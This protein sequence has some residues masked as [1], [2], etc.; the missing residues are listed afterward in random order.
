ML[1]PRSLWVSLC[2][3]TAACV[4]G[5]GG[6]DRQA[7]EDVLAEARVGRAVA[8]RLAKRY[9]IIQDDTLVRYLT[10]VGRTNARFS[11]RAELPFHFG[12]LRTPEVNAYACPGGYIFVTAGALLLMEDEAELAA[13]LAHEISHVSLRHAG[14]FDSSGSW[15]D[16]VTALLAGPGGNVLNSAVKTA[17]SEIEKILLEKGRQRDLE[18]D[19][20]RAGL[21]LSRSAG[22][23]AGAAERYL[24][25]LASAANSATLK[26][27]H[28]S[29]DVRLRFVAEFR[30]DQIEPGGA[31]N[32]ERFQEF[33]RRL[34]SIPLKEKAP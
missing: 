25:R 34:T 1:A 14:R 30:S 20:D 9:G 19:A 13:V 18:L 16:F 12:I 26:K 15:L 8:A 27:T 7:S 11:A 5:P 23:D 31:T 4:S 24:S 2:L 17:S 28:P 33:R 29:F 10:L 22:Y 21:M 6:L 32:A 3:L